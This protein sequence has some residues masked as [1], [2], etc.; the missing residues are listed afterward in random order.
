M[1]KLRHSNQLQSEVW[2]GYHTSRITS[3]SRSCDSPRSNRACPKENNGNKALFI[4]SLLNKMF[5][6]RRQSQSRPSRR[7]NGR[8]QDGHLSKTVM[9]EAWIQLS[10]RPRNGHRYLSSGCTIYPKRLLDM[11]QGFLADLQNPTNQ[12]H[13][14]N[15][16]FSERT[17]PWV[18]SLQGIQRGR[19]RW[20]TWSS[21]WEWAALDQSSTHLL[22]TWWDGLVLA[23]NSHYC[24]FLWH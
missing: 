5:V 21:A 24:H 1:V 19:N 6:V 18:K 14:R 10:S 9:S 23:G 22:V 8:S 20:S 11:V 4:V 2:Q 17:R 7:R 15:S 3:S 16:Q 12:S 13:S